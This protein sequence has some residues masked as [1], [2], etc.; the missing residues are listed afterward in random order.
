MTSS[1]RYISM[2]FHR[3]NI[4][5]ACALF[6]LTNVH[7]EKNNKIWLAI[8]EPPIKAP[9]GA[10]L[11]KVKDAS[12]SQ[13]KAHKTCH[14]NAYPPPYTPSGVAV[15]VL[16]ECEECHVYA[17]HAEEAGGGAIEDVGADPRGQ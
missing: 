12:N 5:R 6:S 9:P 4:L 7:G 15:C 16:E 13:Y 2:I 1:C 17:E 8:P 14:P 10:V 3:R 11:S